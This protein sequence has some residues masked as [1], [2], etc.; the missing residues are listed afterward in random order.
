MEERTSVAASDLLVRIGSPAGLM[1]ALLLLLLLCLGPRQGQ[2]VREMSSLSIASYRTVP[3]GFRLLPG[4]E[5][6]GIEG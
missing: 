6:P 4:L 2:G 1:S 5:D 3:T